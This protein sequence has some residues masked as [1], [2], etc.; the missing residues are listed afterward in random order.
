MSSLSFER[1]GGRGAGHFLCKDKGV[2]MGGEIHQSMLEFFIRFAY[3]Q[4]E[5]CSG[6]G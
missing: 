3:R 5:M 4:V 2:G 1:V 6:S